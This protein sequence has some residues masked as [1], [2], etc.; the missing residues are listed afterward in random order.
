MNKGIEVATSTPLNDNPNLS[1]AIAY[2]QML[3]WSIFPI[4]YK[5]KIP[6]T[7][8][9]FKDATND[10]EQIKSWWTKYPNA[11]IGLPTGEINDVLV[12]DVDP[13]NGGGISFDRLID[14]FEPLPPTVECL[15]GGGGNHYYLKYDERI[16]KSTLKGYPGIDIQS[17]GK[18]VILPPSTHPNGKQYYWEESSKP[19]ST[20]LGE[21]PLWF[22]GLFEHTQKVKRKHKPKPVSEYLR[23]LEGVS[24]GERNNALMSLIG[25][26]L[27]R[28]IDYREAFE[29]VH[30]W[31][32]SRVD[33]PLEKDIVTRAFNNILRREAEKR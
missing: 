27:A 11:G 14:E 24:Q 23:I 8:H 1:A 15:T 16:N 6:I 2:S 31:N 25:H 19:V 17:D 5:T 33:P 20:E 4:H 29:I 32:E 22:V 10:I 18:Y 13:R 30:I 26:L 12:I 9:G 7:Q 3:K 28:N 21:P